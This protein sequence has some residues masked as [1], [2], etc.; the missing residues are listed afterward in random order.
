[1]K[2]CS[3]SVEPTTSSSSWPKRAFQAWNSAG[4]QRLAR[5]HAEAE[6]GE[7]EA[8]L[9][10]GDLEHARVQGRHRRRAPSAARRRSA[11][12]R[13]RRSGR[14]GTST[15]RGAHARREVE[16]VAE[17]EGEVELRHREDEVVGADAEDAHARP[18]RRRP[19]SPRVSAPRPWGAPSSPRCSPRARRRRGSCA[20]GSASGQARASDVVQSSAPGAPARRRARPAATG[21]ARGRRTGGG[22]LGR[23]HGDPRPAIV[24]DERVLLGR[25]QRVHRHADRAEPGRAPERRRERGRIV[26]RQQHAL[27]DVDAELGQGPGGPRRLAR[28]VG[29][30]DGAAG[31]AERRA[32][33]APVGEVAIEEERR[34]VE[35]LR[36]PAPPA[37]YYTTG[38]GAESAEARSV[39]S[40]ISLTLGI[41]KAHA[42]SGAPPVPSPGWA[43][44]LAQRH[45][46]R[47]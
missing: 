40:G 20:R 28:D 25:H 42:P 35:G 8:A 34:D 37:E 43:T 5:G 23:H 41:L 27:L 44:S 29:V 11:R 9:G 3:A 22:H 26:Q 17:A 32:V 33:A 47:R 1:M 31:E 14:S 21:T 2:S 36:R 24:Q 6:R 10:V 4:G 39:A 19:R 38:P 30:G 18:A 46:R 16:R 13:A 15:A 45:H 12:R 7:V